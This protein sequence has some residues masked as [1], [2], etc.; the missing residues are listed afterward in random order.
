MKVPPASSLNLPP[1][2]KQCRRIAL[3]CMALGEREP[4]EELVRNRW[5][6]RNL[7]YDLLRQLR[8][9]NRRRR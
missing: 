8:F 4:L 5:E 2:A 9:S 3:F 1:T 7:I 6:A